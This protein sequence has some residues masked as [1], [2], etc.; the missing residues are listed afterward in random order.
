M[1]AL[2]AGA[3]GGGWQ[4]AGAPEG[5]EFGQAL[6]AGEQQRG[7]A[8]G[9]GLAAGEPGDDRAQEGEEAD[10]VHDGETNV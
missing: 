9:L 5:E 1:R 3:R 4:A 7:F 8:V 6:D 10:G 2:D